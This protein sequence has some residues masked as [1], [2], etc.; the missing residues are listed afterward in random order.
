MASFIRFHLPL[1][2]GSGFMILS[3]LIFDL[4]RQMLDKNSDGC[5]CMEHLNVNTD[6]FRSYMDE[7]YSGYENGMSLNELKQL[8]VTETAEL[9][10]KSARNDQDMEA[11]LVSVK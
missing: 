9:L 1:L 11:R 4:N 5:T 7:D 8:V 2:E 6:M 10:K 3:C